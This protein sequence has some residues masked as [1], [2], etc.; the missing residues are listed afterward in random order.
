MARPADLGYNSDV[1][2]GYGGI[3]RHAGFRF[4]WETVQVRV[5]LA[6][7]DRHDPNRIFP[8]GDGFGLFVCFKRFEDIHFCIGVVKRPE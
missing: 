4:R 5:L 1:S 6:A 2:R 8:V 3:G 7:P